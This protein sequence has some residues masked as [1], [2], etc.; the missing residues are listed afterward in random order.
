MSWLAARD[1]LISI[2][3]SVDEV[4]LVLA[5]PPESGAALQDGVTA[6][7]TPPPRSTERRIGAGTRSKTYNQRIT[8]VHLLGGDPEGATKLVDAAVEAIDTEMERHIILGGSATSTGTFTWEE[9]GGQD[10]PPRSGIWFVFVQGVIDIILTSNV[11]RE[12]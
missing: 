3:D 9:A 12:P 8:V 11:T 7:L 4:G 6:F 10:Y 2:V 1:E 5:A